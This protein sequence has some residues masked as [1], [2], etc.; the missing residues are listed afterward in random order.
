M[1]INRYSVKALTP[2]EEFNAFFQSTFNEGDSDTLAGM[3]MKQLSHMPKRGEVVAIDHY[4]F[5]HLR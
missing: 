4:L 3:L 1:G 2:I 5:R